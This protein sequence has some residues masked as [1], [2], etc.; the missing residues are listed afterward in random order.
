M[1][2]YNKIFDEYVSITKDFLRKESIFPQIDPA[3]SEAILEAISPFEFKTDAFSKSNNRK[4]GILLVHG[5][6][7][8]PFAMRDI[9]KF[10]SF[11]NILVRS[12]LL[13]GHG[14]T[15]EHLLNIRLEEWLAKVKYGI[16]NLEKD[17]DD[18]YLLGLSAGGALAFYYGLNPGILKISGIA[19][20]SPSIKISTLAQFARVV[21]VFKKWKRIERDRD[22]A[23]YE[24]YPVNGVYQIYRLTEMLGETDKSIS[25]PAIIV[26]SEDD[27]TVLSEASIDFFS[28]RI[29]GRKKLIV[30]K[31]NPR[32]NSDPLVEEKESSYPE[33]NIL[34]FSHVSVHISPDNPH[35]GRNGDYKNCLHYSSDTKRFDKCKSADDKKVKYGETNLIDKNLIPENE[36][37][38]RLTFNPDFDNMCEEIFTFLMQDK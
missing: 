38:R 11:K 24:S 29:A 36:I 9:G 25:I 32:K 10:F 5:F 8:T 30:Y 14:T 17:V 19:A 22:Y 23:K 1:I 6:M 7:D 26:L 3:K 15:P 28:E 13:P 34:N 12:I 4:K 37:F 27:T 16:E 31:N 20:I 2:D 33:L 18:V 35:Y 21:G